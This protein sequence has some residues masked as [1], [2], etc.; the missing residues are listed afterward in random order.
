MTTDYAQFQHRDS[1][2]HHSSDTSQRLAALD[3]LVETYTGPLA[4]D[5]DT[6]WIQAPRYQ[7]QRSFINAIST[8]ARHRHTESPERTLDLLESALHHDPYNEF[9]YRDIMRLQHQLGMTHTITHTLQSLISRLA[10]IDA[11]PTTETTTLANQL[12][13]HHPPQ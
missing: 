3:E 4:A 6:E 10:D 9:L 7:A 13:H 1:T 12:R 2:S 5:I 11:E 8:L